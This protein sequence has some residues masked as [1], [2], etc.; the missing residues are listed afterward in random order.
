MPIP[1]ILWV[2]P[3]ILIFQSC[4]RKPFLPPAP[5]ASY[6]SATTSVKE[7]STLN[8]PI[9]IPLSEIERKINAQLDIL[10]NLEIRGDRVH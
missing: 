1:K 3:A 4:A 5:A 9:E 6:A 10:K 8:I 7:V 2:L